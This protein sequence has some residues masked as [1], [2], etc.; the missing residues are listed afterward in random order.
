M[1]RQPMPQP[2]DLQ[3]QTPVP[4]RSQGAVPFLQI[5]HMC[6]G[7]IG[8]Q[9]AFGLQNAN[10]TRIF[11]S[12][13]ARVEDIP[14]LW[15]AAP[16]TGLIVQPLIGYLSDR[17][18]LGWLG[19]RRPYFLAGALLA[20]AALICMPRATSLWTAALLL[21]ILDASINVSMEPF[22][23]FIGD[24]LPAD[25][26]SRG[27]ALQGFFIGIGSVVASCLPWLLHAGG[28]AD[29]EVPGAAVSGQVRL[30][31]DIGALVLI[32]SVLWTVLLSRES[33]SLPPATPAAIQATV[34]GTRRPATLRHLAWLGAGVAGAAIV[35][36]AGYDRQ[37]YLLCAG[38]AIWGMAGLIPRR[39]AGTGMVHVI[40][41]DLE[42]MPAVM[43]SLVPVQ[44]FSWLALFAMW[45]YSTPGIAER[46][47]ATTDASSGPY[48]RAADWV[49][50]L[51]AVA[52]P[53]VVR[54]FGVTRTHQINLILG[55]A[56]FASFL[57]LNDPR[58]LVLSMAGI[59]IAWC[60][61]LSLPYTL[62]SN[63][64]APEKMG[65]YMGIFNF[66]IVI[67]Q[68]AAASLLGVALHTLLHD[69]AIHALAIAA[70]SLVL[71]AWFTRRVPE[72]PRSGLSEAHRST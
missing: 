53:R 4:A 12:L 51:Y 48:Q 59:G 10:V 29:A 16:L 19:R 24:Q 65:I 61:I 43:R 38:C 18:W 2:V 55:A 37:L 27:Y 14:A 32:G 35:L 6:F 60:S 45:I 22:R 39:Q 28:I 64:I 36:G 25:Q 15:I 41:H 34:P 42:H 21:W 44:F 3:E 71:A 66:F 49:G 33:R 40:L 8:I 23:A 70:A 50:V 69:K 46:F 7:F 52:M 20:G 1:N 68:L 67:P 11:Q 62:L 5:W 26:R 63:G 47:Y 56:G 72:D 9:F 13:G 58:W 31:F 30:A 54:R 17:T 57:I